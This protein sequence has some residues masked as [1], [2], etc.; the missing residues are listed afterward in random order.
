MDSKVN[1]ALLRK[2]WPLLSK[3]AKDLFGELYAY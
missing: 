1:P 2:S 3:K